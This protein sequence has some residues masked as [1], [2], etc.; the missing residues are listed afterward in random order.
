MKINKIHVI[1]L[2]GGIGSGKSSV[3]KE[4]KRLGAKVIDA[5]KISREIV[6]PH[7]SAWKKIVKEFG[8]KILKKNKQIDRHILGQLIFS[9]NSK[10]KILER[11]THPAIIARVKK[12]VKALKRKNRKSVIVIDAPLLF[13]AKLEK[14]MD[15]VVVVWCDKKCQVERLLKKTSLQRPE[16]LKRIKAQMPIEKKKKMA[17]LLIN[18]SNDIKALKLK[19]KQIWD[20]ISQAI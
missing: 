19:T 7:S 3:L 14:M 2:T 18:N 1:G 15:K 13:E 4:L 16:I 20:K 8:K 9:D 17:D 12:Q 5:D 10:R 6:R 11:I